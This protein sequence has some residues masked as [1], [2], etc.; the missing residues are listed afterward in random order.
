M[1]L[2]KF[3]IDNNEFTLGTNL[4]AISITFI[5]GTKQKNQLL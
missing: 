3:L 5:M 1:K 4:W 2:A